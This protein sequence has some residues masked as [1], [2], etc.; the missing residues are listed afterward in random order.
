MMFLP[1]LSPP[2]FAHAAAGAGFGGR[3]RAAGGPLATHCCVVRV[4]RRRRCRRR[5]PRMHVPPS[6]VPRIS[7]TIQSAKE[8][9][10]EVGGVARYDDVI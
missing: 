10:E 8:E 4:R 6:L 3:A 9:E 1:P 5:I 7:C 2:A